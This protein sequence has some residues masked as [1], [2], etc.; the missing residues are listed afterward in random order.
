MDGIQFS[1]GIGAFPFAMMGGVSYHNHSSVAFVSCA[2]SYNFFVFL[3]PMFQM[4]GN[5]QERGI[6]AL[7]LL[8]QSQN[9]GVIT[10]Q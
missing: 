1:F 7:H 6:Y 2:L 10:L 9:L 4:F 3:Q 5:R 8:Q